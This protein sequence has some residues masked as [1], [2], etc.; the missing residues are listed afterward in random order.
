MA[1]AHEAVL[2]KAWTSFLGVRVRGLCLSRSARSP[3]NLNW[4]VSPQTT[5]CLFE[6]TVTTQVASDDTSFRN[7]KLFLVL[8]LPSLCSASPSPNTSVYASR[9]RDW[10]LSLLHA[11]PPV[12]CLKSLGQRLGNIF[13]QRDTQIRSRK[14]WP[15]LPHSLYLYGVNVPSR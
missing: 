9:F 11:Q 6:S 5:T 1:A 10:R 3:D 14:S 4:A 8:Y 2:S 13:Q 12:D 15:L 7:S